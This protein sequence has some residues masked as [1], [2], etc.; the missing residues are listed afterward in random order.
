MPRVLAGTHRL[1]AALVALIQRCLREGR[2]RL[3]QLQLF[4]RAQLEGVTLRARARGQGC[5][6]RVTPHETAW[7]P[8]YP[9]GMRDPPSPHTHCL[10]QHRTATPRSLHGAGMEH[11]VGRTEQP[12]DGWGA[13]R[14]PA[15]ALQ[16]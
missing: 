1:E 10:H 6:A 8:R 5:R 13:G 3:H 2:L 9:Q 15:T 11:S 12:R 14:L 4:L 16:C 7:V